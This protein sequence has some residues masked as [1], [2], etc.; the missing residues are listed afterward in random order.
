VSYSGND[1]TENWSGPWAEIN[2]NGNVNNGDEKVDDEDSDYHLQVRDNDG[3]G[4]GVQR[5]ADLS[6]Y[7]SATLS[8]EY[9]RDGFDN[10]NDYVMV[11]ASRNGGSSWTELDR[12]LGPGSLD[13]VWGHSTFA[14]TGTFYFLSLR[15]KK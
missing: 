4:E 10:S 13:T 12:F 15:P 8:F 2:E 11:H 1:G 3:G 5:E 14:R 7:T 6:A 9:R